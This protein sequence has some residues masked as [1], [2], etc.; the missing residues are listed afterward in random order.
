MKFKQIIA[1][2]AGFCGLIVALLW[3]FT[4]TQVKSPD[5]IQQIAGQ[6]G[7]GRTIATDKR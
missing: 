6:I 1:P 5:R 3:S 4:T 7:A 2:F